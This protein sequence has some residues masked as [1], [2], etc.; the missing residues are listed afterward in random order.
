M[1]LFL[2][3]PVKAW[4]K[5]NELNSFILDR[6]VRILDYSCG[7][8]TVSF[9]ENYEKS[10]FNLNCN[11]I[12]NASI[13]DLYEGFLC[14]PT[15]KR[16]NCLSYKEL[17]KTSLVV[18][19]IEYRFSVY[20]DG[21]IKLSCEGFKQNSTFP[22]PFLPKAIN[23][24]YIGG[25][26]ILVELISSLSYLYILSVKDLQP[27]F[28]SP[29]N[30]YEIN[31]N[32]VITKI[33]KNAAIYQEILTYSFDGS[34]NLID[35][36]FQVKYPYKSI[37]EELLSY[38]FLEEVRLGVDYRHFLCEELKPDYGLINEYFGNFSLVLPPFYQ[39]FKDNFLIVSNKCKFT[40]LSVENGLITNFQVEN[41]PIS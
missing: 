28:S 7:D 3:S 37:P 27:I 35:K 33:H 12:E 39:G 26:L 18:M 30:S 24:K 29:Y 4:V 8:V 38:L 23:C 34:F 17:L 21:S 1:K 32:L 36:S 5:A 19:G 31:K 20:E 6:N 25:N 13:I 40:K 22:L 16:K 10:T 14:I 11:L 41:Y 9:G 15:P 2:Y